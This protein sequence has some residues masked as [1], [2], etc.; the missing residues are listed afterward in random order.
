MGLDKEY[1]Y[2]G[3]LNLIGCLVSD[4]SLIDLL[5]RTKV[6]QF[7]DEPFH[8]YFQLITPIL[9]MW[10]IMFPFVLE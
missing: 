3:L 10:F 7:K 6:Y 4:Q 2:G 1:F 9:D 5:L 8:K